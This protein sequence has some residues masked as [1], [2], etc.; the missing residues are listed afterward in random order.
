MCDRDETCF[1][2][3]VQTASLTEAT[4]R[5]E[6]RNLSLLG[7]RLGFRET[8]PDQI[9]SKKDEFPELL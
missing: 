9:M 6:K 8:L 5:K 3:S 4:D 2:Q 7:Y 1:S